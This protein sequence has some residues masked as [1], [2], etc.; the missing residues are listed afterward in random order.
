MNHPKPAVSLLVLLALACP[1]STAADMA[2]KDDPATAPPAVSSMALEEVEVIGK[3][4]YQMQ[5]ELVAA[6]DR[7]YLRYNEFNTNDDFDIHCTDRARTG[8]IIRQRDCRLQFLQEAAAEEGLSFFHS[9]TGTT[10]EAHE[11]SR[12]VLSAQLRWFER[13]EEYRQ[14]MR[15]LLEQNP[16]LRE[17]ALTW[18]Q[19][20][21]EYDRAR[22]A[23][24][25]DRWIL[26][27]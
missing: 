27:E 6:Q 11:P 21:A 16:E 3:K 19:R 13:R 14:N 7:F 17:L 5:R 24:L 18:Q 22:K 4:L 23:R 15:R 10:G 25:K 1:D 9:L 12:Y 8:A 20:Q 2:A 26:F